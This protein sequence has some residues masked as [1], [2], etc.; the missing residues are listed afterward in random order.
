MDE[1]EDEQSINIIQQ[2]LIPERICEEINIVKNLKIC[3]KEVRKTLKQMGLMSMKEA[4][5]KDTGE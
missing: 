4:S 1:E 2:A 3:V 5:V